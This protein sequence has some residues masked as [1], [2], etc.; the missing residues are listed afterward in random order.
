MLIASYVRTRSENKEKKLSSG[1]SVR[2]ASIRHTP[3]PTR[4][5][6]NAT[7]HFFAPRMDG[8]RQQQ[9]AVCNTFCWDIQTSVVALHTSVSQK[10]SL[11]ELESSRPSPRPALNGVWVP[12]LPPPRKV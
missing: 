3:S 2:G 4:G 1:N 11:R 8:C 6:S 10:A 12:T 7:R 9:A 5:V